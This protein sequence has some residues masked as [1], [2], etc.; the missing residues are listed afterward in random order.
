MGFVAVSVV[1]THRHTHTHTERL[2]VTLVHVRRGSM[3]IP[4]V[5]LG[6][7]GIFYQTVSPCVI[8]KSRL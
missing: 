2:T 5:Q 1:Q 6:S 8:G 7:L 4:A 3:N